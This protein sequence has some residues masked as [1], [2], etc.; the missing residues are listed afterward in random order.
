[1]S[2]VAL[3]GTDRD[4]ITFTVNG[5]EQAFA[6]EPRLTLLDALRDELNVTGTKKVCEMGNCG[7]CTVL[8][9]GVAVYSCLTLAMDCVGREVTTIEGLGQDGNLDPVQ[10]AFIEADAF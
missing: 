2:M 5:A 3:P 9:D 10:R 6:G 8:L 4:V 7:A 1:M